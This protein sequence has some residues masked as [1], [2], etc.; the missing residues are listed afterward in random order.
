[1]CPGNQDLRERQPSPQPLSQRERGSVRARCDERSDQ[2]LS[3]RERSTRIARRVRA[4]ASRVGRSTRDSPGAGGAVATASASMGTSIYASVSP[5]PNPSPRGRGAQK[6]AR[7]SGRQSPDPKSKKRARRPVEEKGSD[8][9]WTAVPTPALINTARS[10][11]S[12]VR[13]AAPAGPAAARSR[14]GGPAGRRWRRPSGRSPVRS[15]RRRGC[16]AGGASG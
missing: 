13:S 9:F 1:M 5:H 7:D 4:E 12:S 11:P 8:L 10:R 15:W 6:A 16:A 2:H 3:L 14:A